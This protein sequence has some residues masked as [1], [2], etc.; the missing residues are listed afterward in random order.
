[1]RTDARLAQDRKDKAI[2]ILMSG[3]GNLGEAF[4]GMTV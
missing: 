2:A 1:M 4:A 3:L